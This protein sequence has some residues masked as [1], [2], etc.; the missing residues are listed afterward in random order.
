MFISKLRPND[1]V[2]II[3]FNHQADIILELTFKSQMPGDIY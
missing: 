3:T 1:S 2:G